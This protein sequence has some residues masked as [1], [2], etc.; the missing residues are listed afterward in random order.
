MPCKFKI[1]HRNCLCTALVKIIFF[2]MNIQNKILVES[3]ENIL[4]YDEILACILLGFLCFYCK[5]K[6][7]WQ[8]SWFEW[9]NIYFFAVEL[10]RCCWRWF[11]V[12]E[13]WPDQ[14]NGSFVIG[15]SWYLGVHIWQCCLVQVPWLLVIR[16]VSEEKLGLVN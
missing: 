1:Y 8:L 2:C 7:G 10:L 15:M 4:E 6:K 9:K 14:S 11:H 13:L 3:Y 16:E 5:N 12:F